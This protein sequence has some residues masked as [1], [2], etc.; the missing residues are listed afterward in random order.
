MVVAQHNSQHSRLSRRPFTW[1]KAA[2]DILET[3]AAY[4][5]RISEAG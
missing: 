1:T 2:G 5:P 3:V 4:C